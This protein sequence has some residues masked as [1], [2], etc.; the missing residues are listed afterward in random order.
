M[1]QRFLVPF[2]TQLETRSLNFDPVTLTGDGLPLHI[3]SQL[4]EVSVELGVSSDGLEL[5]LGTTLVFGAGHGV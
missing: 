4:I 2:I 3:D 1:L 5:E